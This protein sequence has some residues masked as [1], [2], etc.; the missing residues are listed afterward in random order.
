M[1]REKERE[2]EGLFNSYLIR[3]QKPRFLLDNILQAVN[4]KHIA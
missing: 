2:K 4:K 1:K 3:L